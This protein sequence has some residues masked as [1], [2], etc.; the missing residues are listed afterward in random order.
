M[1]KF[2]SI[3]YNSFQHQFLKKKKSN[4]NSVFLKKF[5]FF[6][7]STYKFLYQ[8][9]NN[10]FTSINIEFSDF[11]FFFFLTFSLQVSSWFSFEKRLHFWPREEAQRKNVKG[12][13]LSKA[14]ITGRQKQ[15]LYCDSDKAS[16]SDWL[17][18][19]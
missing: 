18:C 9:F 19:R 10:K 15:L 1:I 16:S 3:F 2:K 17:L 13:E 12:D 11:F 4:I 5:N 8:F 7:V 14:P 6:N